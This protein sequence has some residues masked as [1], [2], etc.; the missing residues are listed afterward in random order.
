MDSPGG[1]SARSVARSQKAAGAMSAAGFAKNFNVRGGLEDLDAATHRGA[2]TGW[3]AA[4][5][6]RVQT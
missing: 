5:L 1:L 2:A 4:C 6:P 3:K